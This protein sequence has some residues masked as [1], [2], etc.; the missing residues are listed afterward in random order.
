LNREILLGE[1][2]YNYTN[3]FS[4]NMNIKN[5][6]KASYIS[7]YILKAKKIHRYLGKDNLS[8]YALRGI[9][10]KIKHSKMYTIVGPSG[11]GKSTLL[12]ILGLLDKPNKGKIVINNEDINKKSDYARTKIRNKYLGFIFQFHFLIPEFTALENVILP[13]RKMGKLNY[14]KMK[15]RGINLLKKVGLGHKLSYLANQLSGG[16]QQRVAIARSLSNNPCLLLADE[17]TGNLDVRNSNMIFNLLLNLSKKNRRSIIMVTH[18]LD[19]AEQSDIKILMRDGKII[20]EI[21]R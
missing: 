11:C 10:L 2:Q 3:F 16:E 6:K 20:Q 18:N 15:L 4:K 8:V 1:H 7:P 5:S 12:Y 21:R 9:D 14:Q 19:L 13:M 17:P